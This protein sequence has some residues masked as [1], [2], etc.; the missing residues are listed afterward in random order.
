[1]S[2]VQF[3]GNLRQINISFWGCVIIKRFEESNEE[4]NC[5]RMCSSCWH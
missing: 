4:Y 2:H 3:Y 5:Y 1:M